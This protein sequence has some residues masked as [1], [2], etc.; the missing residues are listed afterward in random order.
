MKMTN[1]I[2]M[3]IHALFKL[4]VT[5]HS[6]QNKQDMN[7]HFALFVLHDLEHV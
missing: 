7:A 6:V 5:S 4:R 1:A 2:C 3:R